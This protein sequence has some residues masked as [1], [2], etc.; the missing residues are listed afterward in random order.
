MSLFTPF[1]IDLSPWEEAVGYGNA[2]VSQLQLP[3]FK[4]IKIKE[5]SDS[6][7]M[8]NFGFFLLF[9]TDSL[10]KKPESK[11]CIFVSQSFLH[12]YGKGCL[13]MLFVYNSFRIEIM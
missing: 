3:L 4:S 5:F 9:K 7:S 12:I 2:T 1:D 13:F 6:K 10:Q 8:L 11:A